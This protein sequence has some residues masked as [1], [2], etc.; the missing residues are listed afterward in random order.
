MAAEPPCHAAGIAPGRCRDDQISL[1]LDLK[2]QLVFDATQS[3]KLISWNRSV[4][5][6][7]G[8]TCEN[9]YVKDLDLT[10]ESITEGLEGSS[11]LFRLRHLRRL[12][13]AYNNFGFS[14]IPSGISNLTGLIYLNLSN[15][16]VAGEIPMEI[17]RLTRLVVLDLSS[18]WYPGTNSLKIT[19]SSR[20]KFLIGNL[21][22]LR[23]LYMDGINMST[24]GLDWSE[25][26]SLS[27]PKLEVLSMSSCCLPGPIRSSLLNLSS[28]SVVQLSNN[29]LFSPFPAFISNFSS[30]TSLDFSGCGL[31]GEVASQVFQIPTLEELVLSYNEI[32]GGSVPEIMVNGSLRTL[33]LSFTNFSGSL[34][35]S[36]SKLRDLSVIEL[37][38][39]SFGG[40]IPSSLAKLPRLTY[41]DLFRNEFTGPIPPFT[42]ASH[43]TNIVL[44]YNNLSGQI[45][46]VDWKSMSNLVYLELESNSLDG[47]IPS[48]LLSHPS[49][50]NLQLSENRF[51]GHLDEL[52]DTSSSQLEALDFSFNHLQGSIPKSVLKIKGL[53]YLSL[54]NNKFSGLLHIDPIELPGDLSYLDL[55]N[56][57]LSV[58][59]ST[60]T[61]TGTIFPMLSTLN[62]ASCQLT[63]FPDF[64]ASQSG[65][66]ILDLSNNKISGRIPRWIWKDNI[67]SLN[68]S[69]NMLED[70][71]KPL[72]DLPNLLILDL[73]ANKLRGD[74][75]PLPPTASY[76]DYS[77]NDFDHTI[78]S[79]IG[80]YLSF[81]I[82][83]SM[84]NN[85]LHGELPKSVCEAVY[86][87]VLDLSDNNLIGAIPDCLSKDLGGLKVLKLRNN[88]LTGSIADA[89]P[90]TCGFRTI[91][92]NRNRLVGQLP[93]SLGNCRMIEVLD[94]GNNQI[95]DSFPCHLKSMRKLSVLVLK[96]NRFRGDIQCPEMDG[97]GTW[98]TLQIIDLSNNSFRGMPP[99][100]IMST[101]AAMKSNSNQ[102]LLDYPFLKL[103]GLH[104]QDT[105]T[106][107]FKDQQRDLTKILT[108]FTLIDFSGNE[109]KGA[110]PETLG[111]LKALK[112]LNLSGNSFSGRIPPSLGNLQQLE[113]LD[114][115]R[116][117][118]NGTIPITLSDLN[119]LSVL[120]LS[121]NRLEGS[122]PQA[123]QFLT[124]TESSFLGNAGLCGPPMEKPCSTTKEGEGNRRHG[125]EDGDEAWPDKRIFCMAIPFGGVVGFWGFIG[126]LMY[127]NKAWR[128][129]FL[130]LL[131]TVTRRRRRSRRYVKK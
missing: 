47:G 14:E 1:L 59:V 112:F 61:S 103:S 86:L 10:S 70:F 106:I 35:E 118:L 9:G 117:K 90:E 91:D 12:N 41:L 79:D 111:T 26:L 84:A 68:L 33:V 100:N 87:Q 45:D 102:T 64:L 113:S 58:N 48:T 46:S 125:G 25:A 49:L 42:N 27:V 115:S 80:R 71:E 54:S 38:W 131:D 114:L 120:N 96:S 69:H 6:F 75:L 55:S 85:R 32:L 94:L 44:S 116:N 83:F 127:F 13:L 107:T 65:L 21:T 37:Q 89:F 119:F 2:S 60:T 34:P 43:L 108:W 31:Y 16:V 63:A 51:S 92:F 98:E 110:M 129:D 76:L 101:W 4:E 30:L 20:L 124:F 18:L 72:P 15:A 62:L 88:K 40:S 66:S 109:F 73:H 130:W 52:V 95:E 126:S 17:S 77:S 11:A 19:I 82:Y 5:Y 104:Y 121:F 122:I 22:E 28:L 7:D 56:N 78:P 3:T 128:R 97:N 57:I 39:C 105:A 50:K 24:Q 8:V 23:E 36:I 123:K 99:W 53:K 93:K 81:T 29:E 67:L 74:K